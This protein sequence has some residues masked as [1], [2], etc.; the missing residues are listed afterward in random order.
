MLLY[1]KDAAWALL[2]SLPARHMLFCEPNPL[3]GS[4][5]T[6]ITEGP[7]ASVPASICTVV[8]HLLCQLGNPEVDGFTSCCCCLV[9]VHGPFFFPVCSQPVPDPLFGGFVIWKRDPVS[10]RLVPDNWDEA[11]PGADSA[12]G[13]FEPSVT[14]QG[15]ALFRGPAVAT[16]V[17]TTPA[18]ATPP[19]AR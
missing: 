18:A 11:L 7:V 6:T 4:C 12:E 16:P 14:G 5:Q 3:Q 15:D 17:M 1:A 13:S 8:Q 9:S 2:Q 10:G 19:A